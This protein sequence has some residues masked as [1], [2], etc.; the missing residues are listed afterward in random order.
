MAKFL[1]FDRESL[2]KQ[3]RNFNG[4]DNA[5]EMKYYFY[6]GKQKKIAMEQIFI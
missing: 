6:Y 3:L 4:D 1:Y 2:R 5:R